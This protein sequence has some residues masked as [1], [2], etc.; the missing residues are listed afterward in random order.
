M[1]RGY[2]LD[3]L[4]IIAT[5]IIFMH[6]YE[7]FFYVA[8]KAFFYAK[9]FYWGRMVELF[10]IISG[11]LILGYQEKIQKGLSFKEFYLKRAYRLLPITALASIVYEILIVLFKK[12]TGTLF[13]GTDLNLS[14][15]LFDA[16]GIQA[17]WAFAN[18]MVNNPT[19]YISVLL[20]CYVVFWTVNRIARI[21]NVNVCCIYI[22]VLF[23][24]F[25][26]KGFSINLPFLN[27]YSARGYCSFFCLCTAF[28]LS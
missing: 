21:S 6:H 16:I 23:V 10:F 20:L 14:G 26:I 25:G 7:Q 4:K 12:H 9:Y 3:F 27:E 17:G 28:Q 1:K 13:M 15:A 18:P 19:W 2:S 22:I 11:F 8:D 5:A 24:G